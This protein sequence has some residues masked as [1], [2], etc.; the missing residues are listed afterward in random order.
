MGKLKKWLLIGAGAFAALFALGAVLPT[1]RG[2]VQKESS[3]DSTREFAPDMR[4]VAMAKLII[5]EDFYG[6]LRGLNV[7]GD[8]S[9]EQRI[10]I[11]ITARELNQSYTHN[12]VAADDKFKGKTIAV[13]GEIRK[14]SK[15]IFDNTYLVLNGD[16]YG[17]VLGLRLPMKNACE[18]ASP[19]DFSGCKKAISEVP[20]AEIKQAYTEFSK[21][22]GFPP[23][24]QK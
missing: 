15:D 13:T 7:V 19:Q 14:I 4:G 8:W 1:P 16:R 21:E 12:E 2:T 18:S 5:L 3:S 6:Y 10:D 24:V 23:L 9:D 11:W 22:S 17:Y 20:R